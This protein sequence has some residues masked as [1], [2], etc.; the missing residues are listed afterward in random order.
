MLS[1]VGQKII[2]EQG[3]ICTFKIILQDAK[4]NIIK[5]KESDNFFMRVRRKDKPTVVITKKAS[6]MDLE[7]NGVIS[8]QHV[9]EFTSVDTM[10]VPYG[11]Y[12]Y[13]V[14]LEI[15]GMRYT[16]VKNCIF[17]LSMSI[18]YNNSSDIHIF[19]QGSTSNTYVY[20][21]PL[22]CLFNYIRMI[23]NPPEDEDNLI[24]F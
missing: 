10:L 3:E 23:N 22:V 16:V 18:Q 5:L 24:L 12:L 21:K 4:G 2:M 14:T 7:E 17:A 20:P 19:D 15:D 6:F 11:N 9:F 8:S 13:D 1:I